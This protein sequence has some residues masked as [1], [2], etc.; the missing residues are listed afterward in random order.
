MRD[1][2]LKLSVI[3][4]FLHWF[5]AITIIGLITVGIYME[6][7]EI[8][9]LYPW[10]KSFGVLI[11]VFI[12]IRVIWRFM[13]GWLKPISTTKAFE[14][15]IA[16]LMHYALIIITIIMPISGFIMS[17]AGGFGV[18]VFGFEIIAANF[19][20]ITQKAIAH[21]E[22]LAKFA[23]ETHEIVGNIAIYV[24]VLH[25]LAAIKH[26]LIDKDNILKRMLGRRIN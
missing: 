15:K 12:V 14:H 5:I 24:I 26:H 13:N 3:T 17:G 25:F 22:Q 18:S 16:T 10:H 2:K 11:A 1:T 23:H 6:E 20:P 8:S 9:E 21:N 19:D 7:N 4:I